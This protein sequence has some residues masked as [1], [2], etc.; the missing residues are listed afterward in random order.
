M[1]RLGLFT[2]VG[3]GVTSRHEVAFQVHVDH[4]V[5]VLFAQVHEHA[6]AQDPALFTSSAGHERVRAVLIRLS[7]PSQGCDVVVVGDRLTTHGLDLGDDL[8]GDAV[9][10]DRP[11]SPEVVHHD[12]GAFGGEEQRVL[13]TDSSSC[14]VMIVTATLKCTIVNP[15]Q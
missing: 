8:S 2:P 9:C 6:I 10:D 14:A 1:T 7:P 13:S 4:R 11:G 5:P 12:L 3:G 15:P